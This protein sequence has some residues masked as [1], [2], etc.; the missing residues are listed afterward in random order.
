MGLDGLFHQNLH[1]VHIVLDIHYPGK[2]IDRSGSK[3]WPPSSPDLTFLIFILWKFVKDIPYVFPMLD[4]VEEFKIRISKVILFVH[5]GIL[6]RTWS[7][8]EYHW[9][10]FRVAKEAHIQ[11][12]QT[13]VK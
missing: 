7:E 6:D 9:D 8:L 12:L 13:N 4:N 11:H 1:D 3:E 5:K 10:I 2:W